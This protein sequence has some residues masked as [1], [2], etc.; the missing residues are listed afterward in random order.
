MQ[1]PGELRVLCFRFFVAP[2][3]YV[4]SFGGAGTWQ[5]DR[6]GHLEVK[7]SKIDTHAD[8]KSCSV[9]EMRMWMAEN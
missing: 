5:G 1:I 3:N 2:E 9:L 7:S 4:L 8:A 6:M